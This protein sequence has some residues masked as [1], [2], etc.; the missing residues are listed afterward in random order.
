MKLALFI[1]ICFCLMSCGVKFDRALDNQQGSPGIPGTW[2][3]TNFTDSLLGVSRS[4]EDSKITISK[5]F[6]SGSSDPYIVIRKR[7]FQCANKSYNAE[8][9]EL[10]LTLSN[11]KLYRQGSSVGEMVD[12]YLQFAM[13]TQTTTWRISIV[14]AGESYKYQETNGKSTT[15]A[16]VTKIN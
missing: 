12:G 2:S 9:E 1:F 16:L 4:C 5:E 11:G 7:S 13:E 6:A 3:A 10:W 15:A 14:Q 8:W